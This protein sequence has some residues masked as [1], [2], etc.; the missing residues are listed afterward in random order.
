M[1]VVL[2]LVAMLGCKGSGREEPPVAS[3]PAVVID[4]AMIDAAMIDAA[5]IDAVDTPR[6]AA[7]TDAVVIDAAV[8]DAA[9]A[10]K[11]KKAKKPSRSSCLEEC[12][13]RNMYTHCAGPEGGMMPCPCHCS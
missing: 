13:Q 6:D 4:A 7:L 2:A 1:R 5:V 10:P 9:P 11:P 12:R 3:R 8:V